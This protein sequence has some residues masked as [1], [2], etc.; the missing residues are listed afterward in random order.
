[1]KRLIAIG[2]VSLLLL[3]GLAASAEVFAIQDF[4]VTTDFPKQLTAGSTYEAH[5][6]FRCTYSVPV[7]VN[8]SV[9]HPLIQEGEWFVTVMLDGDKINCTEVIPGNFS[10]V[11]RQVDPG[12]H[13]MRITLSSLPNILPDTYGITMELWSSKVMVYPPPPVGGGRRAT[14]TPSPT[15]TPTVTPTVTPTA[16]PT[17]TPTVI[18]TV[19]PTPTPVSFIESVKG[20]FRQPIEMVTPGFEGVFAL[21]C[22]LAV[23]YLV[24]EKK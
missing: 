7:Q 23:A 5:Y 11:E 13:D 22:L 18:P 24:K 2:I 6:T 1:M 15:P 16:T 20:F 12:E 19:T 4:Q 14:P 8:F 21:V 17:V 3:S 10:T 9:S